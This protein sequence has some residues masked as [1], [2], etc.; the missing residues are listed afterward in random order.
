[1]AE[2]I[3]AGLEEGSEDALIARDETPNPMEAIMNELSALRKQ[4]KKLN[5]RFDTIFDSKAKKSLFRKRERLS[6][7][8]SCSVSTL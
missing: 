6:V 4:N 5:K 2:E 7:D 1:M 3:S 8:P